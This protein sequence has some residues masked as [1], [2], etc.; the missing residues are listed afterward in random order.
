MEESNKIGGAF[1][2]EQWRKR[3]MRERTNAHEQM[4][5]I[6]RR[7]KTHG[8]CWLFRSDVFCEAFG[9]VIRKCPTKMRMPCCSLVLSRLVSSFVG[10]LIL[11]LALTCGRAV[12][13]LSVMSRC[14]VITAS[15][16]Y[17]EN[18]EIWSSVSFEYSRMVV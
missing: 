15:W 16:V 18:D 2:M 5:S 11:L 9:T 1:A 14:N 10:R 8:G 6:R 4:A 17:D 3:A 12:G 7:T 13:M